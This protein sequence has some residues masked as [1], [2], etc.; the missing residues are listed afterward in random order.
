MEKHRWQ[1]PALLYSV[2]KRLSG[3]FL[4][5]NGDLVPPAFRRA[6]P[7]DIQL[8]YLISFRFR[9]VRFTDFD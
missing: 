8:E 5:Q 3:A 4:P 6:Q 1:D 2:I 9:Y 7:T